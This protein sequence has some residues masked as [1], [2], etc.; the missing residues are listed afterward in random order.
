MG[1]LHKPINV[2][3]KYTETHKCPRESVANVTDPPLN[4]DHD[5]FPLKRS[6]LC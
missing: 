3:H 2:L 5:G 6:V 1:L 4:P